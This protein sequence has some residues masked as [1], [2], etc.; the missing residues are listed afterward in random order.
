M[1]HEL[2]RVLRSVYDDIDS[3]ETGQPTRAM[4]CAIWPS[5][6]KY[7]EARYVTALWSAVRAL[8]FPQVALEAIEPC[9]K[10]INAVRTILANGV[11]SPMPVEVEAILQQPQPGITSIREQAEAQLCL[12][13]ALAFCVD[14]APERFLHVI[15]TL[16]SA[17]RSQ[18]ANPTRSKQAWIGWLDDVVSRSDRFHIETILGLV[19]R[20]LHGTLNMVP[21]SFEWE[22]VADDSG[23]LEVWA[24][25]P[26]TR[27]LLI[28]VMTA[29]PLLVMERTLKA[30]ILDETHLVCDQLRIEYFVEHIIHRRFLGGMYEGHYDHIEFRCLGSGE[31]WQAP[32]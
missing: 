25:D 14:S 27:R 20:T 26:K 18:F 28:P 7:P 23:K 31:N 30:T 8:V 5:L 17:Q 11:A 32:A 6:Q 3:S 2:I 29:E 13:H 9:A 15:N 10:A 12:G 16:V 22:G 19:E 24:E 1:S 4:I 21:A